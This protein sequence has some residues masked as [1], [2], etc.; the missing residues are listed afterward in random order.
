M[1]IMEE[2]EKLLHWLSNVLDNRVFV[3]LTRGLW[4]LTAKDVLDYT[5]DLR[6]GRGGQRDAWRGRQ[7]AAATLAHMD[8]F[9]KTV[10]TSSMG[11]DL[12]NK[13]LALPQ[14]SDRAHKLLADND[15]TV[16]MSYDVSRGGGCRPAPGAFG[17]RKGGGMGVCRQPHSSGLSGC[18][19]C[20]M[21][22]PYSR[23]ES[24]AAG[25]LR[26]YSRWARRIGRHY[27]RQT[28]MTIGL[29]PRQIHP[30]FRTGSMH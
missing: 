9:F 7:S 11:N 12:Q 15:T 8:G 13:D 28:H 6:E 14:H 3:A 26:R 18:W 22:S 2:V 19:A 4:D 17:G 16:H 10:L 23:H 21:P 25:V 27:C 20:C 24:G 5:E 1:H 29:L 30:R